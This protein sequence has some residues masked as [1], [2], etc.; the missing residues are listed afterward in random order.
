MT[1]AEG[2]YNE[3]YALQQ[4]MNKKITQQKQKQGRK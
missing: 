3:E 4:V 1:F 2:I